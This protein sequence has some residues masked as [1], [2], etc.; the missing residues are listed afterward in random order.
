MPRLIDVDAPRKTLVDWLNWYK[1]PD[2]VKYVVREVVDIL[3]EAPTIDAEPV[4]HGRW[5]YQYNDSI[6]SACGYVNRCEP[7]TRYR[8]D[9]PYCPSCGAKMDG[10]KDND[11]E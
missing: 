10:G 6:C 5:E 7:I 8:N 3:D 1:G 11:C 9:S 4:R 2:A